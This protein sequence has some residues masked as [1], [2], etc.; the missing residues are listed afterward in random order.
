MTAETKPASLPTQYVMDGNNTDAQITFTFTEGLLTA[1]K[2]S[3]TTT[4]EQMRWLLK[5]LP[6]TEKAFLAFANKL[7]AHFKL[8][9]V[10]NDLSFSAF[11]EHYNYKVGK[12][13][14]AET[15]WKNMSDESRSKALAYIR[16]YKQMCSLNN[17]QMA[18][19]TT[20]LN[21]G[22]YE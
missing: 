20:Y 22:Y 17:T 6:H 3:L 12:K 9:K 16:Q 18:Y 19:P 5:N 4:E 14:M 10:P 13:R 7:K 11:W 21:Q 2:S 1:F 15:Y 8:T